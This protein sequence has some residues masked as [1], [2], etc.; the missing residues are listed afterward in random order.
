MRTSSAPL[1]VSEM[2]SRH[3]SNEISKSPLKFVQSGTFSVLSKVLAAGEMV[4]DKLPATPDRIK[5]GGLIA[6]C[7]SGSLAGACVFKANGSNAAQGAL[8]GFLTAGVATF[9]SYLLRKKIVSTA[10][11]DDRWIGVAEDVLVSATGTALIKYS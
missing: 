5:A 2:L 1:V 8:L 7:L 9:G 10:Q 6:R 11:V 4:A 3:P